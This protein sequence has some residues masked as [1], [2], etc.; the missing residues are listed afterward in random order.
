MIIPKNREYFQPLAEG[1]TSKGHTDDP[2]F[3]MKQI[4]QKLV[5]SLN[6]ELVGIDLPSESLDPNKIHEIDPNDYSCI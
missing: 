5:V 3:L 6:I 4:Y 1:P 2:E